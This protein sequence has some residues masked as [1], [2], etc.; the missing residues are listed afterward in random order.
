MFDPTS[1]SC[2]TSDSVMSRVNRTAIADIDECYEA[3]LLEGQ[4]FAVAGSVALIAMYNTD[5]SVGGAGYD[6]RV[7]AALEVSLQL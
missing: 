1:L 6:E 4:P 7:G 3:V 2:V 5:G